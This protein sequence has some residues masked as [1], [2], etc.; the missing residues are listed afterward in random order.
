ME[1]RRDQWEHVRSFERDADPD[2]HDRF[3]RLQQQFFHHHNSASTTCGTI[4]WFLWSFMQQL[5]SDRVGRFASRWRMDRHRGH[6]N[7]SIHLRSFGGYSNIDIYGYIERLQQ[8]RHNDHHRERST[9]C[10]NSRLLWSTLQQRGFHHPWRNADRWSMDRNRRERNGALYLQPC[11]R[12]TDI[13]L[14]GHIG[15]L[16]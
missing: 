10:T 6:W 3:Q 9:C 5:R 8:Q 16:Q 7:G 1:W 13:D 12:D 14:H 11:C 2:L 15:R 4:S